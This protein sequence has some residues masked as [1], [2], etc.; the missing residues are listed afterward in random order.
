MP[1]QAMSAA[2]PWCW[3][4]LGARPRWWLMMLVLLAMVSFRAV[5]DRPGDAVGGDLEAGLPLMSPATILDAVDRIQVPF[6]VEKD[7]SDVPSGSG[8]TQTAPRRYEAI[9]AT[10]P[11]CRT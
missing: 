3:R 2:Y 10:A 11:G 5:M 1:D 7:I 4:P 8:E 9:D 6:P